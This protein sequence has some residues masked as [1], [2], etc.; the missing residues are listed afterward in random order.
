MVPIAG[1]VQSKHRT[2]HAIMMTQWLPDAT[3][4]TR[5]PVPGGLAYHRGFLQYTSLAENTTGPCFKFSVFGKLGLN[6][7]GL[8]AARKTR[9]VFR[10][11]LGPPLAPGRHPVL[12]HPNAGGGISRASRMPSSTKRSENEKLSPTCSK[13]YIPPFIG[14]C[15]NIALGGNERL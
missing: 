5:A 4:A 8:L 12:L 9:K 15:H 1:F 11:P 6:N 10:Q 3:A 7:G 14:L 2:V 13:L